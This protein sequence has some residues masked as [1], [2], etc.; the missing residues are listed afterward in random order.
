M[1]PDLTEQLRGIRRV[2]AETVAPLVD[3]EYAADVLAGALT[4]IGLLADAWSEIPGFLRWDIEATREVLATAG[5]QAPPGPDEPYDL[6]ALEAHHRDVRGA[7]ESAI[8]TIVG[9][10]LVTAKMIRLFRDRAD[11]HPFA[12]RR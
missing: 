3:D 7:L 9:D 1:R 10:D 2:L 5:L 4:T 6:T 11:R 12:A 8:P